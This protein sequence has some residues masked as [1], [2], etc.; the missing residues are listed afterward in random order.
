MQ[1][2]YRNGQ[3]IESFTALNG[4]FQSCE[5]SY[6]LYETLIAGEANDTPHRQCFLL[7]KSASAKER[8]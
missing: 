7:F 1:C 3:V 6:G 8:R 5:L 4:S 2:S